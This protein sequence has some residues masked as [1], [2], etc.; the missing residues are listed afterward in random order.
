M[1]RL[2]LAAV[3]SDIGTWVQLIVVGSLIAADTGSALKTGLVALATFMPQGIASPIGGLLADRFD[4]RRVFASGLAVQA[5]MTFVLAVLLGAGVRDP[6]VLT[7]TIL[8]GSGAGAIGAPSYSAM[9]PDL[10]PPEELMAMVSL[11]IYS[12]NAGR[13]VGP[14]LGTALT[15]TVG[16]AWTIAFNA[17]TFVALAGAVLSVRR[18]FLPP[19][20]EADDE[21]DDEPGGVAGVASRLVEGWQ[22]LRTTPG[23]WHGVVLLVLFNLTIVPFMGLVPIYAAAEFGGGTGLA[24][25][26][27][28]AQGIGAILGSMIVTVLVA[29]HRRSDVVAR[30]VLVASGALAVYAMAPTATTVPIAAALLGAGAA[31]L[32]VS[33]ASI[34][35]R[36]APPEHRGRVMAMMQTCM[37]TSYG[38][39]LIVVGAIGDLIDLRVAFGLGAIGMPIAF[40]WLTRRSRHWRRA[41]DGVEHAE[42]V[43]AIAR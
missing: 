11:G 13:I 28:S 31:G 32:F 42:P 3:V 18:S 26:I 9:L 43:V 12:W 39:G 27:S 20:V 15:F 6:L 38:I 37:G 23:C 19:V 1:R 5:S 2:W 8:V 4:R 35:Q 36:D 17:A 7:V 21:H 34:V 33:G 25:A 14:L 24:G 10:V 16:P 40:A 30:V 29:R 41:I 22:A